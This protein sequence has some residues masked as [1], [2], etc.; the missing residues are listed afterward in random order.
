MQRFINMLQ[1]VSLRKLFNDEEG[2][3]EETREFVVSVEKDAKFIGILDYTAEKALL[4]SI[5]MGTLCYL[6]GA[7][8]GIVVQRASYSFCLSVFSYLFKQIC[9]NRNCLPMI[10]PFI[11]RQ[12]ILI[13]MA[14]FSVAITESMIFQSQK[15]YSFSPT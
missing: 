5:V 1:R 10:R 6:S 12:N 11:M 13:F 3:S 2:T 15:V 4:C 8:V 9:L 14:A 7:E